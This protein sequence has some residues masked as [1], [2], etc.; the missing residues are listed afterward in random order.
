MAI[1]IVVAGEIYIDQVMSGFPA[2]PQ[3][4][5]ESFA[6]TLIREVGGGAPHT[7]AG[8][9]R[10]G[11][12]VS[13]VGPVGHDPWL[14]ARLTELG[15]RTDNLLEHP[16]EPTGTTVAVSMPGERTFFTYRGANALVEAALKSVPETDHLHV[17]AACDPDLL[18]WLCGRAKSVSIDAGWHP[19]WLRDSRIQNTLRAF[20]WF[21]PNE[22][23]AA[24]MTGESEP[25]KMME[26]FQDLGISTALKLGANGSASGGLTAPSIK[27]EPVD[28][29]GAGDCFD[30]GF[31]D[32]WLHGKPIAECLRQGNICGALSTRKMGG[33]NGFPTRQELNQWQSNSH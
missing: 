9:A 25:N 15:L 29:T 6:S 33:M 23:E 14:R 17:G 16:T 28:T 31:L 10:L 21:M 2:W 32:A 13:L 7:A 30:A 22:L 1:R 20:R 11:H 12:D 3:P 18:G 5:E 19:D 24:A 8:L 27:I 4:G 26:R